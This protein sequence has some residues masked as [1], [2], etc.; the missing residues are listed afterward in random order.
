MHEILYMD[1]NIGSFYVIDPKLQIEKCQD[2]SGI[3]MLEF[4]GENSK[5]GSRARIV[6][7]VHSKEATFFSYRLEYD[8]KNNIVEYKSLLIGFNLAL[9]RNIKCLKVTGD[10]NM[11]FSQVKL[12]FVAKNV[13]LRKYRDSVRDTI[14]LFDVFSINVIPKEKNYVFDSLFVSAFTLQPC[15][16]VL[17]DL[18]KMEVVFRPFIHDNI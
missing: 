10:S 5:S 9:N 17:Q 13:R 7:V 16:E 3:W 12:K 4:D 8:C 11:V 2:I 18:C 15:E 6:L 1:E 14:E